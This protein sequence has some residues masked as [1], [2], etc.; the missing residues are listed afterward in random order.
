MPPKMSTLKSRMTMM[1]A[2]IHAERMPRR[3]M[4]IGN[5]RESQSRQE[6]KDPDSEVELATPMKISNFA[7]GSVKMVYPRSRRFHTM[8]NPLRIPQDI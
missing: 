3:A 6:P 7:A 5:L 8:K 2:P 1:N 4:S